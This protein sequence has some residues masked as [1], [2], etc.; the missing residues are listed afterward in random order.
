M[1]LPLPERIRAAEFLTV[2][3]DGDEFMRSVAQMADDCVAA[4][5][6]TDEVSWAA[7]RQ[8]LGRGGDAAP[9]V[10][11]GYALIHATEHLRGHV[12]QVA[13]VRQLWEARA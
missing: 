5:H 13:L 4:L 9:E 3:S 8:T 6:S 12:D 2:V 1:G 11:A 10:T 7:P